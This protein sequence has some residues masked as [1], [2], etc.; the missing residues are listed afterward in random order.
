VAGQTFTIW[1]AGD[2]VVLGEWLVE[3][4]ILRNETVEFA[5]IA[6]SDANKPGQF[7]RMPARIRDIL[8]LDA[9]DLIISM[10]HIPILSLEISTEAGTGHN[11]FQRFSRLAA[12]VERGVPAFYIYPEAVWVTR[13]NS[14]PRWDRINPLIFK[15]LDKVMDIFDVPA[16]LYF[17]PSEYS[18]TGSSR[19]SRAANRKGLILDRDPNFPNIPDSSDQH[20]AAMFGHVDE[21]VKLAKRET[22]QKSG[23]LSLNATWARRWRKRM[24]D[25]WND[26][27]GS[28]VEAAMSPLSST[29]EI[30]T[31]VLLDYL[32]P[33][34]SRNHD[35]GHLLPSR[36]ITVVYHATGK[37]R[38]SGDP[39]TGALAAIDYLKCRTG[40]TYE[41][42][43]KNLV[44]AFGSVATDDVGA[45]SID[46]PAEIGDFVDPIQSMYASE[47]KVLLNRSFDAIGDGIPRYMMQVRYGT[48]YTKRK[49][50]RIYAYFCDAIVFKDGALWRES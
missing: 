2:A 16:F 31:E 40:N 3:H 4:T 13:Q 33:F 27:E 35:F 14:A 12:A 47:S 41:D 26:R 24:I 48:T 10:G 5:A 20:M 49:D 23:S 11:A 34:A 50:L 22:P 15:T 46:G 29:V 8:Y 19:P 42:R 30:A 7:F 45:M 37:Y 6:E 43:N 18:G 1:Y 25:Y 21:L 36:E 17:Y 28:A 9:P 39:Y 44:M 38:T 32:T